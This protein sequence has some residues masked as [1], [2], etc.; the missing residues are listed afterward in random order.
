MEVNVPKLRGI[1]AERGYSAK[2]LAAA[3]GISSSTLS[4]KMSS[5]AKGFTVGEMHAIVDALGLDGKEA[6]YIFLFQNSH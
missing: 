1:M 2:K 3:T 5:G 6:Q 4:R